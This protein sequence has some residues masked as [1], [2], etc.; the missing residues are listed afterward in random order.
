[1]KDTA[2]L[3]A[4]KIPSI[5]AEPPLLAR[6]FGKKWIGIYGSVRVWGIAFR[7][8]VYVLGE[9]TS[10]SPYFQLPKGY[11]LKHILTNSY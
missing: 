10:K 9:E 3:L 8:V 2:F 1:M 4:S 6:I 7:G 11:S 5:I